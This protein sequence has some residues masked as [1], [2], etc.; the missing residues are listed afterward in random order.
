MSESRTPFVVVKGITSSVTVQVVDGDGNDMID[1][2]T[3]SEPLRAMAWPGDDQAQSFQMTATWSNGPL[4]LVDVVVP[5]ANT[6]LKDDGIYQWLVQLT[7]GSAVLARGSL[8]LSGYPGSGLPGDPDLTTL[9][10]VQLALAA[11]TLTPIQV[12]YLPFA[13]NAASD[14]AR[15]FCNRRFTRST[16]T[17]YRSPSIDG[18][19]LLDEF[20]VN[21]VLRISSG[22]D[23]AISVSAD[24]VAFQI[25]YVSFDSS[26]DFAGSGTDQSYTGITLNS[27]ADGVAVQT[28]IPFAMNAKIS[29]LVDSINAIPGWTA[30]I[31][32]ASY[33]AWPTSEIYCEDSAQG[34]M[35]DGG[36]TLQVFSR[37]I[38]GSVDHRTGMLCI[39]T[40]Y[41]SVGF[42]PRWGPDW[43]GFDCPSLVAS[44]SNVIR[45]VYD[46]GFSNIPPAVQ[47][48]V[49]EVAKAILV[50][51]KED[52]TLKSESIGSY[53][54][55]LRD[56][57]DLMPGS[58]RQA[59]GF[60]TATNA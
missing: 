29:D 21:S 1:V 28:V 11:V 36:V 47:Q 27:V 60:Y 43:T 45:I 49:A 53:K 55:E 54:Y 57:W 48:A 32:L 41:N 19:I 25:A 37:D 31:P 40:G 51:F 46:A 4:G 30:T 38:R 26:G 8:S 50:R 7:D 59:L 58:A 15:R 3:G 56:V 35:T 33:A 39:G 52:Y 16:Y 44:P 14:V 20:P 5:G 13:V 22:L 23:T 6:T 10:Y 2:F 12:D 34:A 24:Q 9:S 18:L 42:G 17:I